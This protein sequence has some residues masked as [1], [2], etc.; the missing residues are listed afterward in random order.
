MVT[1]EQETKHRPS[2]VTAEVHIHEVGPGLRT[3]DY[4]NPTS[5]Q[6]SLLL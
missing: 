4:L 2:W 6:S 5:T 1:A 3:P